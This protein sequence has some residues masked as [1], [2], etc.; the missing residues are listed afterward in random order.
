MFKKEEFNQE[1]FKIVI[2]FLSLI[3]LFSLYFITSEI[4]NKKTEDTDIL[5]LTSGLY[6]HIN[7]VQASKMSFLLKYDS[8]T[9]SF[10]PIK[11][12]ENVFLL[13]F[14]KTPIEGSIFTVSKDSSITILKQTIH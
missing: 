6:K 4:S 9:D 2:A 7:T 8:I 3:L 5:L 12:K 10:L 13:L 1:N 11:S 14:D